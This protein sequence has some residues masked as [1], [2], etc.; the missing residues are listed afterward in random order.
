MLAASERWAREE[1]ARLARWLGSANLAEEFESVVR[2]QPVLDQWTVLRLMAD[3]HAVGA[4][5]S[6][7]N[8]G[9]TRRDGT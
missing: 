4:G 6:R 9:R 7:R 5:D 8:Y 3:A 1:R 2:E